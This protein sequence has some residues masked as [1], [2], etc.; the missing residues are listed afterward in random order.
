MTAWEEYLYTIMEKE[1]EKYI[2]YLL[3]LSPVEILNHA[4][5]YAVR[6]DI[7]FAIDC[8][9]LTDTQA[10]K[11]CKMPR[12]LTS[13]YEQYLCMDTD[14]MEDIMFAI[15]ETADSAK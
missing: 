6:E 2:E 15:T 5:E 14:Y 4:Y 10:K 11:L 1:Q 12:P 7:L 8:L 3:T 9:W 13:V